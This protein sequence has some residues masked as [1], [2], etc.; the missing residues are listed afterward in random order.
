MV[1]LFYIG[2]FRR[3]GTSLKKVGKRSRKKGLSGKASESKAT[4][5]E[6]WPRIR[7]EMGPPQAPRIK[8]K[9]TAK[10]VKNGDRW[11]ATPPPSVAKGAAKI[12]PRQG[13]F[14]P[15]QNTQLTVWS[16]QPHPAI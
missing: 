5:P 14:Q 9:V 3:D 10:G 2:I 13:A 15:I 6:T 1:N 8:N 11:A 7:A 12:G 16:R 4:R